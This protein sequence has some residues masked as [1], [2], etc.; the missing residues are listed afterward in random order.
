MS[1]KSIFFRCSYQMTALNSC[2]VFWSTCLFFCRSWRP[3]MQK[4]SWSAAFASCTEL[5][6]HFH[7]LPTQSATVLAFLLYFCESR[8]LSSKQTSESN[9][10]VCFL[11]ILFFKSVSKCLLGLLSLLATKFLYLKANPMSFQMFLFV[12]TC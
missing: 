3:F 2:G 10:C 7:L 4:K 1:F 12:K 8:S 9:H 11:S 6:L 5:S